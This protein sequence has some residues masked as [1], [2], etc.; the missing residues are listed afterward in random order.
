MGAQ[1]RR[2]LPCAGRGAPVSLMEDPT[3][4]AEW[5]GRSADRGDLSCREYGC[6]AAQSAFARVLQVLRTAGHKTEAER[7]TPLVSYK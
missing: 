6:T 5:H 3:E 7:E 4:A 2:R 1:G